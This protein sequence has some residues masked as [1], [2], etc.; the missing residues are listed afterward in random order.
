MVQARAELEGGVR[1]GEFLVEEGRG[2]V[3]R[4]RRRQGFFTDGG[5]VAP[6]PPDTER[7]REAAERLVAEQDIELVGVVG[8][9]RADLTGDDLLVPLAA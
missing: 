2:A 6:E 3:R 1:P 9:A 7:A 4:D 5:E 8:E